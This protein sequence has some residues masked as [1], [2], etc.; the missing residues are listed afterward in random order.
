MSLPVLL[1]H[2]LD[3]RTGDSLEERQAPYRCPTRSGE[4]GFV[5][6]GMAANAAKQAAT[7]PTGSLISGEVGLAVWTAHIFV[8]GTSSVRTSEQ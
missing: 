7:C 6:A 5:A 3:L 4:A 8:G 1:A 2:E